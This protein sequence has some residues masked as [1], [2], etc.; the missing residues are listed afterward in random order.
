LKR[1]LE[2][3]KEKRI[4]LSEKLKQTSEMLTV[5]KNLYGQKICP[6]CQQPISDEHTVGLEKK[7]KKTYDDLETQ[8][9]SV[10]DDE[11]DAHE[12][13][14]LFE[15]LSKREVDLRRRLDQMDIL[16]E[17]LTEDRQKLATVENK[18]AS[19]S[20]VTDI[21]KDNIRLKKELDDTR[22]RLRDLEKEHALYQENR[23]RIEELNQQA[24]TATHNQ[25]LSEWVADAVALT[26]E[27]V[28][29]SSL[30]RVEDSVMSCLDQFNLFRSDD[31]VIDLEKSKL[32]PDIDNRTFQTLSGSEKAILYLGMKLALSR[33]MPGAQFFVLDNPTLHLDDQR[34]KLMKD[35]LLDLLPDKQIILLTNDRSFADLITEGKRIDL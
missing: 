32:M 1:Q 30:K 34:K 5:F 3:L 10:K 4:E 14:D 33:L 15:E 25:L 23:R 2:K 7:H 11:Q 27:S 9:C 20:D 17:E 18:I 29:G 13:M 21:E 22:T 28:I 24:S 12:T 16:D 31:L 6:T 26:L 8:L 35:Y 19:V